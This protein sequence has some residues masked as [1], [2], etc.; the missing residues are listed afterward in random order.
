M[1]PE[2]ERPPTTEEQIQGLALQLEL[3]KEELRSADE[4]LA[5]AKAQYD[6]AASIVDSIQDKIHAIKQGQL[7]LV[8]E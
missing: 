8:E 4:S 5:R 1:V 6:A 7:P 3:A 2:N